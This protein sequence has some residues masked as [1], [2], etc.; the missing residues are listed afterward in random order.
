MG[1]FGAA[2]WLE[3]RRFARTRRSA[4]RDGPMGGVMQRFLVF[5]VLGLL[6]AVAGLGFALSSLAGDVEDDRLARDREKLASRRDAATREEDP[7]K[8]LYI[9]SKLKHARDENDRLRR[10]LSKVSTRVSDLAGVVARMSLARTAHA[11]PDRDPDSATNS[12]ASGTALADRLRDENGKFIVSE[13]EADYFRAVQLRVDRKRRI[14]GQT[15]NYMRRISALSTRREIADVPEEKVADVEKVLRGFVTLNDDLVSTYVRNPSAAIKQIS[16]DERS[17]QLR[18][19]REKYGTDARRA[20]DAILGETDSA[21][22]SKT[23][24]TN[25]WGI[26]RNR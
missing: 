2:S 23:V 13:E 20:L 16:D 9:E 4:L 12:G 17:E 25:P 26:R 1:P 24:F 10:E 19:A 6:V 21:R 7:A 3:T 11:A 18:T 14:D 15:R 5:L 22:I 8:Q